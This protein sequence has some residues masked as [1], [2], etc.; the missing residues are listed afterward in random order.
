MWYSKEKYPS[1]MT[2]VGE[3]N[4]RRAYEAANRKICP[5]PPFITVPETVTSEG[6]LYI[7][8][9]YQ[10][11]V[12]YPE[13]FFVLGRD[14]QR[15][16]RERVK[17]AILGYGISLG[18]N[19]R[20]LVREAEKKG[21]SPRDMT[22]CTWYQLYMDATHIIGDEL[23]E[24]KHM[25]D[26]AACK[27]SLCIPGYEEREFDMVNMMWKPLKILEEMSELIPFRKYDRV[28]MGPVDAPIKLEKALVNNSRI[29]I[30]SNDYF[31]ELSVTVQIIE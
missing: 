30:K 2:L 24:A 9:T 21:G 25:D 18:M 7:A 13:L 5:Y 15:Y 31:K 1:H 22:A 12:L 27:L 17:D 4:G 23:V 11:I 14:V 29:T 8:P 26:I 10:D 6:K 3:F 28:Y 16:E 19:E 20:S